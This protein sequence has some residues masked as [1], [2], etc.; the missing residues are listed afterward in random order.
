MAV[1]NIDYLPS[2]IGLDTY[3]CNV[4][5]FCN[6]VQQLVQRAEPLSQGRSDRCT[7]RINDTGPSSY[8]TSVQ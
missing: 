4:S 3:L 8:R 5:F 6:A 2:K 7:S 1:A